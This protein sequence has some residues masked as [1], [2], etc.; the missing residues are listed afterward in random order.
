MKKNGLVLFLLCLILPALTACQ[1]TPEE[2]LPEE[3]EIDE[4]DYSFVNDYLNQRLYVQPTEL[5]DKQGNV[6]GQLT[7][8]SYLETGDQHNKRYV[9]L[10]NTEIY[11]DVENK[12]TDYHENGWHNHLL[13]LGSRV[14]TTD[15]YSLYDFLDRKVMELNEK[16]EYPVYVTEENR[17]GVLLD[18]RILYLHNDDIKEQQSYSAVSDNASSVPVL[19]YHFF[20]DEESGS[21]KDTNYL[22]AQKFKKQL[23]YLQENDFQTL[24]MEELE[25]YLKKEA[26]VPQKSV[27]ITM[28]DGDPSVLTYAFP[29]LVNHRMNATSFLIC[30]WLGETLPWDYYEMKLNGVELQSH[31]FLM[32]KEGCKMGHGGQLL[33][34]DH[35]KGVEDTIQS[36]WYIDTATVYCYPFGDYNASAIDIVKEAG[37]HMAFTTEHGKVKP[38][39]DLFVLPRVRVQGDQTLE[40][41]IKSIQ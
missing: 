21:M 35:D 28:D 37:I 24:T 15:S 1:K 27:V 39:D 7:L 16:G 10:A 4:T 9:N 18:N 41:F 29:Q 11:L 25:H 12:E 36:M 19:M 34:I 40:S 38:G 32:H 26:K 20:Y 31:S 5:Y 14:F 3:M 33:C 22:S 2:K 23:D 13:E 6:I 8:A 30:G 17:T